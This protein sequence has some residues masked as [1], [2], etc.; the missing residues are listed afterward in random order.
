M[1]NREGN[2]RDS[3]NLD[4]TLKAMQQQFERLN[5]VLGDMR[6][7]MD[8]QNEKLA[9]LQNDRSDDGNSSRRNRRN[10]GGSEDDDS[11]RENREE[12]EE[13]YYFM[14]G[15]NRHRGDRRERNH[16]RFDH[17]DG[18]LNNIKMKIP[19]FQGKNDPKIYLEWEKKIEFIFNCYNYSDAKKVKLVVIQFTDYVVV[20]WDKLVLSRRRDRERPVETWREMKALM[21]K[22]FVPSHYYKDLYQKLQRL[23]EDSKCVEDYY[24]E[25]KMT[26]V[27]VDVNEDIEATIARFLNGLNKEIAHVMEL[28][29]YVE[30]EDMVH[31]AIKVERQLKQKGISK[32]NTGF[33]SSYKPSWK[34][35][36]KGI[37]KEP[38]K[39][40]TSEGLKGKGKAETQSFRNRDIKCF[41]C[42]GSG[43]ISSQCPNKRVM[44]LRDNIVESESEGDK[45]MAETEESYDEV[46]YAVEGK[47]LVSRRVLNSQVKEDDM[48]QQRENIFHTRC[49]INN[50]VCNMIIDGGSCTNVASTT[51]L[52][53]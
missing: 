30:L 41:K 32:Y 9:N 15:R 33:G 17:R 19:S 6:D 27:R 24:K 14:M 13:E 3:S 39:N 34:K 42:L 22:R 25:M 38:A 51:L 37:P 46:E 35:E 18:S 52:R 29:H 1:A 40:K 45:S 53:S 44:V 21:R 50:K 28:Q 11:G 5:M 43:H 26:M 20:W 10:H 48:E 31:M 23:M 49:L 7:I 4:F 12:T 2:S 47:A 16:R 36:E 8:R